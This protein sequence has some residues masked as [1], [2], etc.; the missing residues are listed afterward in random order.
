MNCNRV[1]ENILDYLDHELDEDTF[2]QI[3]KHIAE[4]AVC[5]KMYDQVSTSYGA[6]SEEKK[7]VPGDMLFDS[8]LQEINHTEEVVKKRVLLF[9]IVRPLLAV[10]SIALGVL[11]GT[12]VFKVIQLRN[13]SVEF[14]QSDFYYFNDMGHESIEYNLMVD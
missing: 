6:I 14:E 7:S 4:C 5:R 3:S 13:G 10:A 1:E 11:L 8:I 9:P 2:S 12:Q